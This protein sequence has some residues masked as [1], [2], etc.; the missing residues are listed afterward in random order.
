M[1][2]P[3]RHPLVLFLFAAAPA[4]ADEADAEKKARE[5]AERYSKAVRTEDELTR[6]LAERA[7]KP[8]DSERE[9]WVKRLDEVFTGR[10]PEDP[11][12]WFD[13][14]VAGRPEWTRD[15]S[16]FFAELH[17]RITYRLALKKD[18]AVGRELFASYAAK[19]LGPDSPPWKV[20]DFDAES[21]EV[22]RRLDADRDGSL[23][24]QECSPD[25]QQQFAVADADKDQKI[26]PAEYR[27]YFRTRVGVAT[28]YVPPPDAKKGDRPPP[29]PP[30]PPSTLPV[31]LEPDEPKPVVLRDPAQFP[32]EVPG[33]FRELDTDK[34]LQVGL[35][36]WAAAK[37]QPTE[38]LAMDLNEDG[39]LEVGEYL[40]W[41][42]QN[43][44]DKPT[45]LK[46]AVPGEKEKK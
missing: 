45:N 27:D 24:P 26:G 25:L 36:E 11:A 41:A 22:F 30:P 23:A 7:V 1:F 33:W 38:F 34:D 46:A 2:R 21:R 20:I 43:A 13:M 9:R 12:A 10:V 8:G 4:V 18:T 35:Y 5:A 31:D 42:K 29:P 39:L 32:K 16:K 3:V 14:I 28:Q 44:A 37:R 40:R 15:G 6:K 17:E 19:F